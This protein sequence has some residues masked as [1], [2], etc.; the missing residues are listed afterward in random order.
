MSD[1]DTIEEL[2]RV[3]LPQ[4][5]RHL[6]L[7]VIKKGKSSFV[8]CLF[9]KDQKPS[10]SLYTL[11][12]G[13]WRY[14]CFSCGE[15]GDVFDLV[16]RHNNV[17]FREA[18][19]LVA[20]FAGVS[21]P[22]TSKASRS[23]SAESIALKAFTTSTAYEKSGLQTWA[24]Q[25][26]Y[27]IAT[28][29]RFD[30]RFTRNQKLST[31]F[32]KDRE[33]LASLEDAGLVV[34]AAGVDARQPELDL[35]I[36]FR[37]AM[38]GDR[39]V[40]PVKD[41][42]GQPR[43][44]IGRAVAED[45][46]QR[47]LF[48]RSFQKSKHLFG[49]DVVRKAIAS[50]SDAGEE[51]TIEPLEY[52]YVV[53]GPTDVLRLAGFGLHAVAAMGSDLSE[54][55]AELLGELARDALM[56]NRS[57]VIRVF[58][59]SDDAGVEGT[60]RVLAQLLRQIVK[61]ANFMIEVVTSQGGDHGYVG[62]DPDS[63]LK[64][65]AKR[66]AIERI[67]EHVTAVGQFLL[68]HSIGC[69]S[70]ELESNWKRLP[71]SQKFSARRR[72]ELLLKRDEWN[73]VLDRLGDS[74]FR[75]SF[76][77]D[78][79]TGTRGTWEFD[80]ENFLSR[81][82]DSSGS[83]IEDG[84]I[85]RSSEQRN[86]LHA[87][88]IAHCF[89]QRREFPVDAKSWDRLLVGGNVIVPYFRELLGTSKCKI[90]PLL[91]MS[92]PKASGGSRLKAIPCPEQLSIQQYLLNELLGSDESRLPPSF[93]D[94]IP[95]IRY[96]GGG[97]HATGLPSGAST[98]A[99]A[100][101]CF[102]Y[103]VDMSIAH[104]EKTPG[105]E[106]FFR[107]Y[108][109]CWSEFVDYL[110]NSVRESN[111]DW[112]DDRR[113]YV[114]RLDVRG[115]YDSL[116]RAAID[117]VLLEPLQ[118]AIGTLSKPTDFA[119]SFQPT[120]GDTATRA[121]QFIDVL[122][123]Q[124]FGYQYYDP[125]TGVDTSF[126]SGAPRGMPQ[127]PSLSA[128]LGTIALFPLDQA[129]S[130][131][132]V[133]LNKGVSIPSV[134][135]ARYV[136]DM[137]VIA[138]SKND[139]NRIR[140]LIEKELGKIGLDLSPKVDPLPAMNAIEVQNWLTA[141]RGLVGVSGFSQAPPIVTPILSDD[142]CVD[143]RS[144]LVQLHDPELRRPGVTASALSS[145]VEKVLKC[146]EVRFGD[147]CHVAALIWRIY[148]AELSE[149]GKTWSNS[150]AVGKF[151]E[152]WTA[153]AMSNDGDTEPSQ[154]ML[155]AAIH[156]LDKLLSSRSF[157]S[158]AF[159]DV[160][161]A[162]ALDLRNA[163]AQSIN[164]G[165]VEQLRT[166]FSADSNDDGFIL[167]V[168][169]LSLLAQTVTISPVD[170]SQY[171]IGRIEHLRANFP[172][173]E[174]ITRY[175]ISISAVP[176]FGALLA[177][178]GNVVRDD[179][180]LHILY[181]EAVGRLSNEKQADDIDVLFWMEQAINEQ[182]TS[183]PD[184]CL[185]KILASWLSTGDDV[186][187][188][189]TGELAVRS[190]SV[191]LNIAMTDAARLLNRRRPLVDEALKAKTEEDSV[192]LPCI[193]IGGLRYFVGSARGKFLA[194]PIESV[195]NQVEST[196]ES[197]LN[198]A[199]LA[200]RS[201]KWETAG[202]S[203]EY[204]NANSETWHLLK[205][206]GKEELWENATLG[207]WIAR[208]FENLVNAASDSFECPPNL[209]NLV[210]REGSEGQAIEGTLGHSVEAEQLSGQ[211]FARSA[212]NGLL[213]K[214]VPHNGSRYWRAGI[215]ITDF[216]G[217]MD[218]VA[219]NPLVNIVRPSAIPESSEED[220]EHQWAQEKLIRF[221]LQRL[222]G[223]TAKVSLVHDNGSIPPSLQRVIGRL[224]SFPALGEDDEPYRQIAAVVTT[225]FE[226]RFAAKRFDSVHADDDPSVPGVP[227]DLLA[228]IAR[229]V[230][231]T[232]RKLSERLP[233]SPRPK[234]IERRNVSAWISFSDRV[235]ELKKRLGE[236]DEN[237]ETPLQAL[238]NGLALT[239][240]AD[241]LRCLTLELVVAEPGLREELIGLDPS[242]VNLAQWNLDDTGCFVREQRT[243]QAEGER[244][245]G[246]VLL[247]ATLNGG[248][249][250]ENRNY[251]ESLG[252]ITPLGWCIAAGIVS[253]TL[254][255]NLRL[256]SMSTEND[257]EN[258][259]S[260]FRSLAGFLAAPVSRNE[261]DDLP[262]E[263]D[264]WKGLD[265]LL[266]DDCHERVLEFSSQLE[267]Y[268]RQV[269]LIVSE[270]RW[271]K[272]FSLV[273][274]EYGESSA[275]EGRRTWEVSLGL[276]SFQIEPWRI[277]TASTASDSPGHKAEYR[278]ENEQSESCW[279]E[280]RFK[281]RLIAVHIAQPGI[282]SLAGFALPLNGD[283]SGEHPSEIDSVG[284]NALEKN[285]SEPVQVPSPVK[286]AV[287]E[288][289]AAK[290]NES[291]IVKPEIE[292]D[293]DALT[294]AQ[295]KSWI[296]RAKQPRSHYKRIA[297][298]QLQVEPFG[299]YRHPVYDCSEQILKKLADDELAKEQ[300][301]A[302]EEG[303][304]PD[305]ERFPKKS[306]EAGKH[307]ARFDAFSPVERRRRRLLDEVLRACK[308]FNVDFLVL[309][310][311]STRP[312]TV[313]W[314]QRQL[315][316]RKIETLVWAGTFRLPPF[317]DT[318]TFSWLNAAKEWA[319][320]LPI[321]GRTNHPGIKDKTG[322][323]TRLKKYPSIAYNEIFNPP[324]NFLGALSDES[325]RITELICSEIFL[326]MSPA[327]LLALWKSLDA[328]IQR[329]GRSV[330][331]KHIEEEYV[332]KD[333]IA[334]SRET[335]LC[336]EES[337]VGEPASRRRSILFVPSM[338]PR[339]VDYAI[340]GQANHLAAGMMTVFCNDS[341]SH[342]HGQSCF[343]G[344]DGWDN[345]N[346]KEILGI[347][348]AGPY[349]GLTPGFFRQ[350]Q[351]DR[352]WLGT[353]EQAMVIADVDPNHQFGG[354]PR[355]QNL[356]PPLEMVAHLPI[357]EV[358]GRQNQERKKIDYGR[359][360]KLPAPDLA[361]LV[362]V[363]PWLDGLDWG[364]QKASDM[365]SRKFVVDRILQGISTIISA[366]TNSGNTIGDHKNFVLARALLSLAH[367]VPENA[368]WLKRRAEAYKSQHASNPMPYPPPVATDWLYVDLDEDREDDDECELQVPQVET[369]PDEK[370]SD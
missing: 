141:D 12:N 171:L 138:R 107:P 136:D 350:F 160:E 44:F 273:P 72:V 344:E 286:S 326:A 87:I 53:E 7:T 356:L 256:R 26:G 68:S 318:A 352:G 41:I 306:W 258:A 133:E 8:S 337:R 252:R 178:L 170:D 70:S 47:Y 71:S 359:L 95:A 220:W 277:A 67:R 34:R 327:N 349:H 331:S 264:P 278:I 281:S 342:S 123:D 22:R 218:E 348:G 212:I 21:L 244:S 49:A 304:Q 345:E 360:T 268:G 93:R 165:L 231:Y 66:T 338:T 201:L 358:G 52:V 319:A 364:N 121:R 126:N 263:S 335:S 163:I 236:R 202:T 11:P 122:C 247:L 322:F 125:S 243:E 6:G 366:P 196:S 270:P 135:Y 2:H 83:A 334:F 227:T 60:R 367:S 153:S 325:T 302:E 341:G 114:A 20:Q 370:L 40:F 295:E 85:V 351:A 226:T 190:L 242:K 90:E 74:F 199:D 301:T 142:G 181:H 168:H 9:H 146:V 253:G 186:A 299:S 174:T 147:Q 312:E 211:S 188:R 189:V 58:F 50:D 296:S 260:L 192:W 119:P 240:L 4:F 269:G 362:R 104:G 29:E 145:V 13:E 336:Y 161:Q 164:A 129:V 219:C 82:E 69:R 198:S 235:A 354:K 195:K 54:T 177:K 259:V 42:R 175:L 234:F 56:R 39:I 224:R 251:K 113:Y 17:E 65:V 124:S 290:E 294:R 250:P 292:C 152:L 57:P 80:L 291:N 77:V 361:E 315:E 197:P 38:F 194:V 200:P 94:C 102:S 140:M 134:T 324:S 100:A 187:S 172:K 284:D 25:R 255:S 288:Q 365:A 329:F 353:D 137:V 320:V 245:Q 10:M 298:V 78:D 309:P 116:S 28:L 75:T 43:G 248:L 333:V 183:S 317:Y 61:S 154:T 267:A 217:L 31:E 139:L 130:A 115:Y 96:S 62:A 182:V 233:V 347:P 261:N 45:A 279:T 282:A 241:L 280:T 48:T 14:K 297:L 173:S 209:Y 193:P 205:P 101:T 369:E 155:F 19:E 98:A 191:L 30:V 215:A 303:I 59:D 3:D 127:G 285:T 330:V 111:R 321:V 254:S 314:I 238:A 316:D 229:S 1:Q 293:W 274:S 207:R 55:Q 46:R 300:A 289:R 216:L 206:D 313:T 151:R 92:V 276:E 275:D 24:K 117:R 213:A 179:T 73:D 84:N 89:S 97:V 79:N 150:D 357:L 340:L 27:K 159:A 108:P 166:D 287:S 311:Y 91:A 368:G 37:D 128:Y 63:W 237:V 346:R 228:R 76:S 86:L 221:S 110:S 222:C 156:G 16:Q 305:D 118:N 185:A 149:T 99:T 210:A 343:I 18:L 23:R 203:Y 339:T 112:T 5:A 33:T 266:K 162:K 144:A 32:N 271:S 35:D 109:E 36:P 257:D 169:E 310:E 307:P 157:N 239:G 51:G 332:M 230:I 262:D 308:L 328:L 246:V 120:I 214:P 355:P 106:G 363:I 88:Q 184:N 64:G 232:D 158:E 176:P 131:A 132:I 15:K 167:S 265:S 323:M 223:G 204:F 208:S 103:Q 225:V 272:R 81:R 249:Q 180:P 105:N 148:T 143:R 283:T